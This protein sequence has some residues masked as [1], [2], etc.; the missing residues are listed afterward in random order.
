M[1]NQRCLTLSARRRLAAWSVPALAVMLSMSLYTPDAL[2]CAPYVSGDVQCP[3]TGA[4]VAVP[5]T[6]SVSGNTYNT[7]TDELGH[8]S[9]CVG[10]VW[11]C[12]V[13]VTVGGETRTMWVNGNTY[14][15]MWT[16]DAEADGLPATFC[17]CQ[18]RVSGHIV[19][20]DG[21]PLMDKVVTIFQEPSETCPTR[22]YST[23]SDAWGFFYR[24]VCDET[25]VTV[26]VDADVREQFV[27]EH[28]DFG[29][30][31]ADLNVDLDPYTVCN[32]DCNDYNGR[33]YPGAIEW[34]DG[35]D[36]DCDHLI[37]DNCTE[38]PPKP[39]GS[40]IFRKPVP[41]IDPGEY[42]Y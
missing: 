26:S 8:F 32:G 7:T 18:P 29:T 23:S 6:I 24:C 33:V 12:S 16:Y 31:V 40:P 11:G 25:W 14:F 17:G 42:Q 38:L 41:V 1:R 2:G 13:S 37:D 20:P 21:D 34:C 39:G 19:C 3:D 27:S 35:I 36:N 10:C 22:T 4:S 15:G 9:Y 5:V 28:T 30:Y